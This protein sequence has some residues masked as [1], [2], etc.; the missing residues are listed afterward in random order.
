MLVVNQKVCI[1]ITFEFDA[2]TFW[3]GVHILPALVLACMRQ[4]RHPRTPVFSVM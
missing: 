3:T 1:P 4:L 2:R